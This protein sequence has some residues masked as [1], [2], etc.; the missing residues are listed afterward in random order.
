MRVP[1]PAAIPSACSAPCSRLRHGAGHLVVR[2]HHPVTLRQ[3]IKLGVREPVAAFT[4]PLCATIHLAGSMIKITCFSLAVMM[5]FGITIEP[6]LMIAFIAMLGIM[7]V[8]APGVPGA[9]S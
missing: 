4:V 1:S 5:L 3:A 6:G 8:A 9:P 2:G 7:M